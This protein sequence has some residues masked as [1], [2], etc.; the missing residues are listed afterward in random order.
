VPEASLAQ[1][2]VEPG[3]CTA[4]HLLKS[5]AEWYYILSGTGDMYIDNQ[6]IGPVWPVTQ[7]VSRPIRLKLYAIPASV[8]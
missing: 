8:I 1:A 7:C 3:V 5:T 2:R 4:N 6:L